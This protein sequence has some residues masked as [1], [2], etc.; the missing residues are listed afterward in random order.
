MDFQY[1][2]SAIFEFLHGKLNFCQ[3]ENILMKTISGLCSLMAEI[4]L[5]SSPVFGTYFMMLEGNFF[6]GKEGIS[7]QHLCFI[8][9]RKLSLWDSEIYWTSS[10]SLESFL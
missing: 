8:A 4:N 1:N 5:S 9:M 10:L 3:F 2:V 6:S 7:S